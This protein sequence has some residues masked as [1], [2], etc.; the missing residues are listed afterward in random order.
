MQERITDA[1]GV[2]GLVWVRDFVTELEES[3]LVAW[4]GLGGD[5]PQ[6]GARRHL[7][8][9]I[10][11][12]GPGVLKSHYDSGDI[13]LEMPPILCALADRLVERELVPPSEHPNAIT[14]NEYLPGQGIPHHV[15][16]TRAGMIV[17]SL[18]LLGVGTLSMMTRRERIDIPFGRRDLYQF[19][20]ACRNRPWEHAI[21][22]VR[23][24]R[25][26]VVFRCGK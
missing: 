10:A 15:D 25:L 11:R 24:R 17:S 1:H 8:A 20:G 9:R 13:T 3:D 16:D 23:E 12:Y 4:F 7:R 2:P 18:G 5:H 21:L 14:V 26:S 22:P 6:T 19:T